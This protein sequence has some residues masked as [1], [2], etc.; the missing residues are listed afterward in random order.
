MKLILVFFTCI[1]L[2]A[3]ATSTKTVEKINPL[4]NK[5]KVVT[6]I[7]PNKSLKWS[8]SG[9]IKTS[10]RELCSS[11]VSDGGK[12]YLSV[13][14]QSVDND[15]SMAVQ[16]KL[17]SPVQHKGHVLADFI[18]TKNKTVLK[19][20]LR[21]TPY[22]YADDI[23]FVTPKDMTQHSFHE[24][25]ELLIGQSSLEVVLYDASWV[26]HKYVFTWAL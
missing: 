26:E 21:F 16:L 17:R 15:R 11:V 7:K 4:F 5:L 3:C 25:I 8:E 23:Y 10:G 9:Y 19:K 1:M 20:R 22:P 2:T 24:L 13:N 6:D 12:N 14:F 18:F